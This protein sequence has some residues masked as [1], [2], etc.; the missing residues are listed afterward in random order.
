MILEDCS[1]A[2]N[3]YRT[4]R[5]ER[6]QTHCS[7][8]SGAQGAHRRCE[9]EG[10]SLLLRGTRGQC[11]EEGLSLLLRSTHRQCEEEGKG[12]NPSSSE[13]PGEIVRKRAGV[14]S[15][16]L[17]PKYPRPSLIKPLD[18]GGRRAFLS[19][20]SGSD[21]LTTKG[22]INQ[23]TDQDASSSTNMPRCSERT[24]CIKTFHKVGS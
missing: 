13:V 17:P 16:P 23:H 21:K 3:S 5:C 11:E 8:Q 12:A 10:L 15:L 1:I 4:F 9:E 20:P 7:P 2:L 18:L 19:T 14:Q 22:D 6:R 24:R